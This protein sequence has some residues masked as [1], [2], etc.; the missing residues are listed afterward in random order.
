MSK[1]EIAR[2]RHGSRLYHFSFFA[3][4]LVAL[5]TPRAANAQSG[6]QVGDEVCVPSW[7]VYDVYN[8]PNGTGTW[9]GT[10]VEFAGYNCRM[11]AAP[12]SMMRRPSP[13]ES[14]TTD[15][16]LAA[17]ISD[18]PKD[19]AHEAGTTKHPVDIATRQ[20]RKTEKD[21]TVLI[22]GDNFGVVRNYTSEYGG[23]GVFGY[24]WSSADLERTLTFSTSSASCAG[25]LSQASSCSASNAVRIVAMRGPNYGKTFLKDANGVWRSG[26]GAVLALVGIN[27]VIT[28]AAGDVETYNAGG[29]ALSIK[30]A[31][32][33][34]VAY[35]YN[36]SGQLVT[37]SHSSG[38]TIQFTWV[39]DKVGSATDPSGKVYSYGYNTNGYLS[40]VTYPD[41]LGTKTYH[42][43]ETQ[44]GGLTGITV[45]G[46][47]YSRYHYENG[48]V[49]YSGLGADG[50][51]ERSTFTYGMFSDGN[52]YV[53]V[54]NTLGQTTRYLTAGSGQTARVIGIQRPA[55]ANCP[56]G[57]TQIRYDAA[58]DVDYE[59]DAF[60][61]K[62]DYTYDAYNQLIERKVGVG[63]NGETDQ[64]QITQFIWD[65]GRVGRLVAIKV[66]GKSINEPIKETT[67]DYFPDSDPQARLLK[68]ITE[69]NRSSAGVANSA[70][71]TSYTYSIA[72]NKLIS[73]MTVD[74]PLPGTTDAITY[75]YDSTG[76]L[77]SLSN[78]LGH[79]TSYSSYNGLGLAGRAVSQTGAITDFNYDARG[80][81]T[82]KKD[83]VGQATAT[84][85]YAYSAF[86]QVSKLT[87]ADGKTSYFA[88][89]L[90]GEVASI[91]TTRPATASENAS[92]G[93]VTE[94]RIIKY[95]THGKPVEISDEKQWSELVCVRPNTEV[96]DCIPMPG[97]PDPIQEQSKSQIVYKA[98]IDYDAAGFVSARRG[99]NGQKTSYFYNANGDL[100][101]TTD[102]MSRSVSLSYDRQ[103]RIVLSVD[104]TNGTTSFK[105]DGGGKLVEVKDPRGLVT[106]YSYDG[107]GQLWSQTSPD[108]GTT[109]FWYDAWG[110]LGQTTRAD[111]SWLQYAYDELGRVTWVGNDTESRQIKYT[112]CMHGDGNGKGVQPCGVSASNGAWSQ[113]TYTNEGWLSTRRDSVYGAIDVTTYA[114]D[115]MGRLNSI[116]YPSGVS[117]GYSYSNGRLAAM[118]T[119]IAGTTTTVASNATYLPFGSATSWAYGNGLNRRY[120]YDLDGRITGVSAGDYSAVK[121]SLTYGFNAN[122]EI[123]QITNGIDASLTQQFGYDAQSRLTSAATPYNSA[124][125]QYDAVGNRTGRTDN[126]VGVTLAH[127]A[128]SNRV[129]GIT[130]TATSGEVEYQYDARGNRS[131]A[132]DH[133]LYIATYAYDAFNRYSKVDYFNGFTT[134]MTNYAINALDQ[135]VGKT[136][137]AST[138]RYIYGAQNQLLAESTNGV[139]SSYLWLDGELIGLVRNNQVYYVHSDHLGRPEVVTNDS[140]QTVWRANNYAFSRTV[141]Q[142]SIGGL[143]IGFPGQYYD[144][145]S[146]LWHNGFRDYDGRL[147][148]YIQ[149]DPIGLEG[150]LNTYAYVGGNPITHIDPLGLEDPNLSLYGSGVISQMPGRNTGRLPDYG[151]LSVNYYVF[152]GSITYGR[153]GRV[154]VAGGLNRNYPHNVAA[155]ASL[156]GGWLNCPKK[157][158][159]KK[160][161][162]FLTGPGV[163]TAGAYDVVGGAITYSP[164]SGTST[165][166]GIGIGVS[167]TDFRATGGPSADTAG[168]LNWQG[169]GWGW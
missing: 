100:S 84:T 22:Q 13:P 143:N 20:K 46:I 162:G 41:G 87:E 1:E 90:N 17:S 66:F 96:E 32:G 136:N 9:L 11:T 35:S 21:F 169:P 155:S 105:Y 38:R 133:G 67:Y 118:T 31:R 161:E 15:R 76:N 122:N 152:N 59:V 81:L 147:G 110:R 129:T 121:Q 108:T 153:N 14:I 156:S 25:R 16:G 142:D 27:W 57:S 167:A 85:S 125:F 127:E 7:D 50:S 26:D 52:T 112:T 101:G 102:S 134:T 88:Y 2:R 93:K 39:G 106:S 64:Q 74:G 43:E 71:T 36:A 139:W 103:R 149:S 116:A 89:M 4:A 92:D 109:T 111:G 132:H 34:G 158:S 68:T 48:E 19:C 75:T 40:T 62:T 98:F 5:T 55:S 113:F 72:P 12:A 126:G 10:S 117:V 168:A 58:G 91:N 37:L 78:G 54:A 130:A 104:K 51:L 45:N 29:Q 65:A 82:W 49:K 140:R 120:N 73:S 114:Y 146:G 30:D 151:K 79:T 145:E 61:N 86:D 154:Y 99:N 159:S 141:T 42:Y 28:T 95:N 150:G 128:T 8:G 69:I 77:T 165:E 24:R 157:P 138:S 70:R 23:K 119:T 144:A 47:R 83:Y 135:R 60:G 56:A 166:I 44:L 137:P 148:R 131:W 18:E 115:V 124:V 80:R 163:S 164:G 97:Y 107:L 160:L 94:T 6:F 33:V 53:D 123:A 63:P 3:V